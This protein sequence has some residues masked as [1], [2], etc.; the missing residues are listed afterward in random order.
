[1]LRIFSY[2]SLSVGALAVL[3]LFLPPESSRSQQVSKA[4][5]ESERLAR[6][7]IQMK[8]FVEQGTTPG[9]VMLVARGGKVLSLEAVGYQDLESKKPMRADTIFDIRS[10]TKPVTAIGVMILMEE[11]KLALNDP[12]EKYLPEFKATARETQS[13]PGPIKIHHLLTHTA[14]IPAS[15]PQEIEDITVK[16]NRALTDVVALV[17]KQEPEFAPGTQFR[18]SSSGF[19]ILGRIIEVVSGR[20]YEQFIKERIFDPLGMKDSFFFIPAGKWDRVASIYRMQDGKLKKWEEIRAYSKNAKYPGPEF[21]M[22]STASDLASLCQMMLDGGIFK[23]KRILSRISVETMTENHALNIK[24]AL[25]QRP[26]YQGLGWGLS[27][28]P[29]SDFPLTSARS[30]GHNGAFGSII[31]VDPQ[32]GLIRIF[33]EHLFA[34]GNESNIFMAMAGAAVTD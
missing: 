21:G 26:A 18:Y 3:I 29:M 9:A 24:S 33:L 11:G 7:P 4:G 32:K 5:L 27:G 6:I 25:T 8:S 31:W 17:S 2:K 20:P 34:F 19:A 10:V 28:D 14:G 13:A 1:M 23:G 22:Y 16:R 30:F 12:V 15:R